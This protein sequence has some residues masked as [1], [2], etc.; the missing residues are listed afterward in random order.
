MSRSIGV[1]AANNVELEIVKFLDIYFY[2]I[3]I[4]H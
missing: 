4:I 1:L 3:L 2:E